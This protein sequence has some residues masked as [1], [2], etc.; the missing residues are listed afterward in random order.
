[1]LASPRAHWVAAGV[2]TLIALVSA[3]SATGTTWHRL[4][5]DY[6][7]YSAYSDEERLLTPVVAAGFRGE[8]FNFFAAEV[9]DDDRI[10]FQVPRRPYGT[11]DLHDTVA[12]L[13]RFFL[14]PAIQVTDL[15]DATVVISY[16]ADPRSLGREFVSQRQNGPGIFVSRIA[17]P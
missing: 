9:D 15:D 3:W 7:A 10:Y 13:G 11:L 8:V 14:A 6:R 17:E 12:A 1:M 2:A 16:E 4:N 5:A